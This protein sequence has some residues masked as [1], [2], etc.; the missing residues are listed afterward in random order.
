MER[1][2]ARGGREEVARARASQ[3]RGGGLTAFHPRALDLSWT[4]SSAA[5]RPF[6]CRPLPPLSTPSLSALSLSL[7][8]VDCRMPPYSTLYLECSLASYSRFIGCSR[9]LALAGVHR[10]LASATAVAV[11]P[12]RDGFSYIRSCRFYPVRQISRCGCADTRT[13]PKTP[14]RRVKELR[15]N[16]TRKLPGGCAARSLAPS[17][18]R[19]RVYA[20]AR[21]RLAPR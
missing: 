6:R 9:S 20:R 1:A 3:R 4:M 19:A 11:Q 18:S 8:P 5:R 15:L 12:P 13:P 21:A 2:R 7:S 17:R 14:P 10:H 16:R